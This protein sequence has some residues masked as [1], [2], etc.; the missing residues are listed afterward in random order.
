MFG[1][2]K[3]NAVRLPYKRFVKPGVRLL[4]ERSRWSIPSAAA[5]SEAAL[6]MH[7]PVEPKT[8]ETP[9]HS[10]VICVVRRGYGAYSHS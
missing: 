10:C 3:P 8:P 1:H 4:Q 6:L 7:E 2:A 5:P 9:G